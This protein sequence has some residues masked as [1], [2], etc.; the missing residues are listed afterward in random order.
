M[1]IFNEV[2]PT[3]GFPL[4]LR[5]FLGAIRGMS[6][7]D[8][9]KGYLGLDYLRIT[10]SGTAAFYLILESLKELSPRK[11]VIIPSFTCPL[12]PLAVKRAG[13]EAVICDIKEYSF[14]FE[15]EKLK[16]LC[17]EDVLAVLCVHLAGLPAD[18]SALE[19]AARPKGIFLIE[20][21]AQSL[22]AD[23]RGRKT[24]TLGDFSFFSFCRGKGLTT[25]EGGALSALRRE[26]QD[27]L[28]KKIAQLVRTDAAAEALKIAELFGYWIF[29]RPKLFW[30]VF[31]LPQAYWL[32]RGEPVRAAAEYFTRDFPLQEV[33]GFRKKTALSQLARLEEEIRA[34]REKA[35]FYLQALGQIK[36][37]RVLREEGG[38]RAT[39]P[40]LAI[41]FDTP[42]RRE[43]IFKRLRKEGLGASFIYLR[44]LNDYEYL[45]SI[46][47]EGDYPGA[48]LMA[49]RSLT[50]STSSFLRGKD[51][52]K[53]IELIR[54]ESR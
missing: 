33:S 40:Y 13:L 23:Y 50:L 51:A 17:Q 53:A 26:H 28:D 5:D 46:I 8:G 52:E 37:L 16:S 15:G 31:D 54:E 21:C 32:R 38:C 49:A 10:C 39:Y 24:G 22:G 44:A 2:P 12:I 11:K 20:D 4:K 42:E 25:Y 48:R 35:A 45:R 18:F 14:D 7:E 43:Q 1:P 29:Y 36:G 9:L 27:V 6:F 34:Q 3:S 30:F 41:A 19:A 47:P